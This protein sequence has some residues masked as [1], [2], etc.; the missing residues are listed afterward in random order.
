VAIAEAMRAELERVPGDQRLVLGEL[1]G[2]VTIRPTHTAVDE[3]IG[4]LPTELVCAADL[5]TTHAYPL[6]ADPVDAVDRALR[7]HGCP[8][9]LW[10]TETGARVDRE[11]PCP[12]MHRRLLG[13]HEDPRVGAAFQYTLRNDDLFPTGLVS[14]DL[15][16][17]YP[18]LALWQAW[19]AA[20]G[21]PGD[22][23]PGA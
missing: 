5:W 22:P 16:R 7:A 17:A 23:C 4:A 8:S 18:T 6:G 15:T 2:L 11:D 3:F 20:G 12:V 1:A 21:P 10:I 13:W 19:S 9:P 14:T